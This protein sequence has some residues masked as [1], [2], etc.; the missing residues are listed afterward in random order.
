MAVLGGRVASRRSRSAVHEAS[1][2]AEY[3]VLDEPG[4]YALAML[5][6]QVSASGRHV[7]SDDMGRGRIR[8]A[9]RSV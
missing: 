7:G 5:R 3:D 8:P 9:S 1:Q 4:Q 6:A 2:G